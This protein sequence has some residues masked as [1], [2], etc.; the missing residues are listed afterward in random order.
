MWV[1]KLQ[2]S[3]YLSTFHAEYVSLSQ[4]SR[5]LVPMKTL[6]SEV[7]K[8]ICKYTKRIEFLTHLTVY[9]DNYELVKVTQNL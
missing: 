8:A 9:K 5:D 7:V 3:S 6:I 1:S 2:G 4:S